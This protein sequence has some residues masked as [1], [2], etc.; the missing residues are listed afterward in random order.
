MAPDRT[1]HKN[2]AILRRCFEQT[3]SSPIFYQFFG[4]WCSILASKNV[5]TNNSADGIRSQQFRPAPK[6]HLQGLIQSHGS[7]RSHACQP[8]EV[9]A[10]CGFGATV[11][12]NQKMFQLDFRMQESSTLKSY[13]ENLHLFITGLFSV[14]MKSLLILVLNKRWQ[15]DNYVMNYPG[16]DIQDLVVV[17]VLHDM[18]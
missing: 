12:G 8:C 3:Q 13:R 4:C 18:N 14:F 5:S 15:H 2:I 7:Y 9:L 10:R 11:L 1:T 17:I 16:D 6:A